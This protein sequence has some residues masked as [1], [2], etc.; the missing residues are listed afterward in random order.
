MIF[1]VSIVITIISNS[2]SDISSTSINGKYTNTAVNEVFTLSI[3]S[4]IGCFCTRAVMD[5]ETK[6]KLHCSFICRDN[7]INYWYLIKRL[8]HHKPKNERK[9]VLT[10]LLSIKGFPELKISLWL[11]STALMDNRQSSPAGY[12]IIHRVGGFGRLNINKKKVLI[13]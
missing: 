2:P 6:E 9:I 13:I 11:T 4:L 7:I 1:C 8:A 3:S 5:K 12:L 10:N